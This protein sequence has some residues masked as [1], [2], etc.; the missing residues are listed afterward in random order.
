ML[1]KNCN[2]WLG[3][4]DFCQELKVKG[5]FGGEKTKTNSIIGFL[6]ILALVL[7]GTGIGIFYSS[8]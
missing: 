5:N 2:I 8:L 3:I 6:P 1:K 4:S 7:N